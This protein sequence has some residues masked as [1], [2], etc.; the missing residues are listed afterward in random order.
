M[1]AC[2]DKWK[3]GSKLHLVLRDNGSNFIA[4]LRLA[5]FGCLAHTLQLVVKDAV[6]AQKS[7]QDLLSRCR[8]IVGHLKQSNVAWHNLASI[9]DKL[10]FSIY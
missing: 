5:N 6:L 8:K 2:I 7:V 3:I 10:G 1:L 4:G 9:Q